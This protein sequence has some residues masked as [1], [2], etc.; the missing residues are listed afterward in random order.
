MSTPTVEEAETEAAGARREVE[1]AE[2]A[3]AAGGK[4]VTAGALHVL[5]DKWRHATLSAEGARQ[6]AE[7]DRQAVRLKGLE[8]IGAETDKL[9]A[10][11]DLDSL[12]HALVDVAAAAE[13][14]RAVAG[15]HNA[16]C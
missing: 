13:R 9:A 15:A 1:R 11:A 5:R 6:K 7:R 2:S 3:L 14:A 16:A 8:Q 4:G 12:G 10:G